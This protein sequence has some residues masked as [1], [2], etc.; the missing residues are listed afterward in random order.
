M[1]E[2]HEMGASILCVQYM[3]LVM[4]HGQIYIHTNIFIVNMSTSRA[5]R[6]LKI[7]ELKVVSSSNEQNV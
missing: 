7:F 4:K 3:T 1:L 2:A 6:E 5:M